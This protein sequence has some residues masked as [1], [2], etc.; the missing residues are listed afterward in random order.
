VQLTDLHKCLLNE[1]Q[2]H[3]PLT[4]RPYEQIAAD[5]GVSEALV[6]EAFD[7]LK[8][9]GYISRIGAIIPPNQIGVSTLAAQSIPVEALCE[10]AAKI[11]AYDEVNHNYERDHSLNLWFVVIAQNDAHL[12]QVILSIE[13]E[14]GYHVLRFPLVKA[15]FID[16][17]FGMD[18]SHA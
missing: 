17:S 2:R 7:Y 10:V 11:N 15:F 12:D 8:Q 13:K 4:S 16:L 9:N 14:T 3:F 1:Y 6:L 18:L 5:L